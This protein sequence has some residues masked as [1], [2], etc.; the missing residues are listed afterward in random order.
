[1][2][3]GVMGSGG[4]GG[5]FG[6]K[7]AQ[8]GCDVNF[9]ARDAHLAA[10]REHGLKIENEQLRDIV[11]TNA[12]ATDDPAEIGLVDIVLFAVKLWDTAEAAAL[13]EP[14][15]GPNTGVVSLQNGV[16]KD[17]V[18]RGI[19]SAE[20]VMGGVGYVASAIARPGVIGQ[21]G[22]FQRVV[23]GEYDGAPSA[24]AEELVAAFHRSGLDA[25]LSID[26][27]RSL[28]EK[29]VFLVGLSAV[30]AT[31]RVPIGKIRTNSAARDFLYR[32]MQEA[33][34]VGR[35][36]GVSLPEDYA[37]DRLN[38]VETLPETMTSSM[39]HDLER[40]NR[41]EMEWLSGG[42]AQLGGEVGVPTPA[43][44]AVCA[45]LAVHADGGR[46]Y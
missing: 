42:I 34:T 22:D 36:H 17:D 3:V 26:I 25:E 12:A 32:I 41:L 11:L 14:M 20:S 28:W 45:I 6:A 10:I 40:G 7:L 31:V 8:A 30:T 15:V 38:F 39:H 27:R 1:M 37:E 24:R 4:V 29:F 21:T 35:A 44:D 43:N 2:R 13:I 19:F 18:L 9:V 5:F 46:G 23:I 16:L 33:V